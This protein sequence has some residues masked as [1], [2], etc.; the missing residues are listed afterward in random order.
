ML[1]VS[2]LYSF[3]L[4][5]FLCQISMFWVNLQM[6][7]EAA[8]AEHLVKDLKTRRR[9]R[10]KAVSIIVFCLSFAWIMIMIIMDYLWRPISWAWGAAYV[11]KSALS[12]NSHTYTH[13]LTHSHTHSLTHKLFRLPQAD[14]QVEAKGLADLVT[15]SPSGGQTPCRPS[16]DSHRRVR[17]WRIIFSSVSGLALRRLRSQRDPS[18]RYFSDYS[19][20]K[21]PC[22]PENQPVCAR[23]YTHA[24]THTGRRACTY[25]D[26]YTHTH[27]HA[28]R[29]AHTGI[30]WSSHTYTRVSFGLSYTHARAHTHTFNHR[31]AANK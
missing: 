1:S 14:G 2:A 3:T 7:E 19:I 21:V 12:L 8:D 22:L 6:A 25:T 28:R 13:T 27:T 5:Y 9:Q 31:T 17:R 26:A 24:H 16:R 20:V 15:M 10:K 4:H 11:D 23:A 18:S 29:R 30:H